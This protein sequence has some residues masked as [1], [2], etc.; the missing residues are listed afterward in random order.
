MANKAAQ[1]AV[2]DE[3]RACEDA[4]AHRSQ[5]ASAMELAEDKR[6][7]EK[8]MMDR[9]RL[10]VEA[11]RAAAPH[12]EEAE[13]RATQRVAASEEAARNEMLAVQMRAER[14]RAQALAEQADSVRA[15]QQLEQAATNRMREWEHGLRMQASAEAAEV[16]GV[17]SRVSP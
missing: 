6:L 13:K 5:L 12:A 2:A 8:F 17:Q 10:E 7:I 1:P 9:S 3:R 11:Q 14:Q 16:G 15:A 4:E